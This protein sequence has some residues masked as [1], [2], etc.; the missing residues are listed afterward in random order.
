M[1]NIIFSILFILIFSNNN[2]ISQTIS[3]KEIIDL[4]TKSIG[5]IDESLSSK[6][7]LFEG[8]EYYPKSETKMYNYIYDRN[9]NFGFKALFS[10]LEVSNKKK[11]I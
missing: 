5:E 7:W 8:S 6:K 9:H 11:I 1:K 10:F 2:A 3:L 4:R